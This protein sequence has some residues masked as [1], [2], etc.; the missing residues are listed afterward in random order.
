MGYTLNPAN[1]NL[2]AFKFGAFSFPVLL[3]EA[4]GY[5][6][7]CVRSP[8]GSWFCL[9]GADERMPL[10]DDYPKLLSNDGFLVTEE[11]AKI[12]ARMAEN[13]VAVQRSLPSGQEDS[14][15]GAPE[16][17]RPWPRKIREDFVDKFEAFSEWA[18]KSGG[19]EIR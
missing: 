17:Q 11:E 5:L 9:F 19:F 16:Y 4:C 10:G 3:S 18:P 2:D 8:A 12:M 13:F 15:I 1:E 14:G 6:F 7:P